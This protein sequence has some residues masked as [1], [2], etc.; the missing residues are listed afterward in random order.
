[1]WN[2]I[3]NLSC[4][5]SWFRP[6]WSVKNSTKQILW[7]VKYPWTMSNIL[8]A[9]AVQLLLSWTAGRWL[10]RSASRGGVFANPCS[11]PGTKKRQWHSTVRLQTLQKEPQIA[12]GDSH[13][14]PYKPTLSRS[15]VSGVLF[16]DTWRSSSQTFVRC[17]NSKQ[18]GDQCG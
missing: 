4:Y 11:S 9:D 16:R 12:Y 7:V 13:F 18:D 8:A 6:E 3:F 17:A 5:K 1:M 2:T 10:H 14:L 15:G